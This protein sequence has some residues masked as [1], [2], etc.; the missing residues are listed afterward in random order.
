M[1]K[2][3][4]EATQTDPFKI[5]KDKN[6]NEN[7]ES[8]MRSNFRFKNTKTGKDAFTQINRFDFFNF[9]KEVKPIIDVL[10]MK[11]LEQSQLEVYEEE[12]LSQ[13]KAYKENLYCKTK[14]KIIYENKKCK[15][16]ITIIKSN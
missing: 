7:D 14:T 1:V 10:T 15:F 6:G 2:K 5:K 3:I 12:V 9:E 8:F 11:T 13:M 16:I 4:T